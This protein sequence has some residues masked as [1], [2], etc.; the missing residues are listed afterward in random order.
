MS[1]TRSPSRTAH[2]TD[3][4]IEGRWPVWKLGLLLYP[5]TAATVAINLV[6]LGLIFAAMGWPAIAPVTALWWS[7]PLGVPAT[8][9]AGRWARRLL[10]EG[11]KG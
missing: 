4:A 11:S 5:F 1:G 10:D 6:L 8:W 2:P 7:V 3:G 9:A